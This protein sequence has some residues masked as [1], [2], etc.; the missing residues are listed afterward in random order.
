MDKNELKSKLNQLL[1][2]L[3]ESSKIT[4]EKA[5]AISVSFENL[6]NQTIDPN[7]F[8][9]LFIKLTEE[10]PELKALKTEI[11]LDNVNAEKIENVR[12]ALK[13]IAGDK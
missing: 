4:T 8:K 11:I 3:L 5:Q 1:K 12:N 2:E 10:Y 13:K 6:G 7:D 9:N